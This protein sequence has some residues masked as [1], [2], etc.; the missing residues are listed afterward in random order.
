M[1]IVETKHD[2]R[3]SYNQTQNYEICIVLL[4]K[5]QYTKICVYKYEMQR[6][7]ANK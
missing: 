5:N 2:C 6:T 4:N 3:V 7:N 1:M